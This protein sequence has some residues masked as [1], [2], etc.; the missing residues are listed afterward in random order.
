M[1]GSHMKSNVISKLF[2]FIGTF[3]VLLAMYI[4]WPK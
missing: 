2:Y 1:S 4:A 3:S